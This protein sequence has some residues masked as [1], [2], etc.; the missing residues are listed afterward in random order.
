MIGLSKQC[1]LL[2]YSTVV[3]GNSL[4]IKYFMS[5]GC[6]TDTILPYKNNTKN[7]ATRS[8]SNNSQSTITFTTIVTKILS[9]AGNK[10]LSF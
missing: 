5:D 4:H 9:N 6:E 2:P 3:Y 8:N 10:C 7:K 1:L